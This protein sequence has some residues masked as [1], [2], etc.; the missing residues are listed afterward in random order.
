M[1]EAINRILPVNKPIGI[2]T[3]DVIRLFKRKTGYVGKIG[4]GGTLDPFASGVVLLL[5][6]NTTSRFEEI[7]TW[8][9]RYLAGIRLGA[10]STTLD[11]TGVITEHAGGLASALSKK[12]VE[13]TVAGFTGRFVQKIPAYSAAKHDGVPLYRLARRGIEIT[14][15]K[16]V[17]IQSIQVVSFQPPIMT[18]RVT[19]GG[20]VY[21]RQLAQDIGEKL[22]SGGFLYHLVR[23]QVG[24]YLLRDC[25]D[26]EDFTTSSIPSS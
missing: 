6:G 15:S 4:H 16:T 26:V 21:I 2:S 3:Y 9:K 19:C 22:G 7:K 23:E 8:T 20:G 10:T 18:C 13:Q 11:I 5:L 25:L 17:L 24:D 12:D 1:P 14:K